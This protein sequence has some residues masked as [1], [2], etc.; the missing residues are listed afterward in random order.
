MHKEQREICL[1]FCL[2]L[3]HQSGWQIGWDKSLGF[4]SWW[5]FR[6]LFKLCH[7]F[8]AQLDMHKEKLCKKYIWFQSIKQSFIVWQM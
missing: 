7:T 1:S 8:Q 6:M 4:L 3:A 5:W 2:S